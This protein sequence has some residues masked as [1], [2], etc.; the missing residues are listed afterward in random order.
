MSS[1]SN[2]QSRFSDL[3][4]A[5]LLLHTRLNFEGKNGPNFWIQKEASLFENLSNFC[6]NFRVSKAKVLNILSSGIM[7]Y[8]TEFSPV[9]SSCSLPSET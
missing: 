4:K 1:L 2:T 3:W 9:C 6:S 8:F 7:N 5:T